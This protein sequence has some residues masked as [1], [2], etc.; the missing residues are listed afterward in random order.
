M[1]VIMFH[2][3]FAALVKAGRKTQT[4]RGAARCAAGDV[5]S[6]REWTGRP[7]RSKQ[8]TLLTVECAAVR[9]IEFD[10]A[11]ALSVEGRKIRLAVVRAWFAEADG[12]EDYVGMVTWFAATH[13]LPFTGEL[14]QWTF[15]GP[16]F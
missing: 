6:L 13:G 9:P 4:I 8:R 16:T 10:A 11:G 15:P 3:R 14:I 7:Y 12:F 2:P 1:R 5:L